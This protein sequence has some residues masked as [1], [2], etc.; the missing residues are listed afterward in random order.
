MLGLQ[1]PGTRRP[2]ALTSASQFR[3][4]GPNALTS[5]EYVEDFNQVKELGRFDSTARTPE[6][7]TL[8]S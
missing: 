2:L 4:D 7:T 8:L 3:P 1:L 5:E 6:Q